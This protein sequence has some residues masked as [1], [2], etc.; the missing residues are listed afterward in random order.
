MGTSK[1]KSRYSFAYPQRRALSELE[2]MYESSR[3][4]RRFVGMD[5]SFAYKE[6][7]VIQS[8]DKRIEDIIEKYEKKLHISEKIRRCAEWA[9]LYG[10]ST[11]L[12]LARDGKFSQEEL[13]QGE[14]VKLHV[15]DRRWISHTGVIED[16]IMSENFS[17]PTSYYVTPA[18][19][20]AMV[21]DKSRIIKMN[22]DK[23]PLNSYIE[24]EYW[25]QSLLEPLYEVI[26]D[27]MAA[28]HASALLAQDFRQAIYKISNLEEAIAAGEEDTIKKRAETIDVVKSV[29]NAIV[30]GDNEEYDIKQNPVSG[31]ADIVDR[32]TIRL[33]IETGKPH[34]LLL[35]ESPSGLGA[36]GESE[37]RDY[38]DQVKAYQVDTLEP[39]HRRIYNYILANNGIKETNYEIKWNSL[40]SEEPK[41]KAEREKI[42]AETDKIYYDMEA[43]TSEEIRDNRFKEAGFEKDIILEG[44]YEFGQEPSKEDIETYEGMINGGKG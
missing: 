39:V 15:L 43:I 16:D 28:H 38:Y 20:E 7:F 25:G 37:K 41:V 40:W 34:T 4:A 29:I 44:D 10:G 24:N 9:N 19:G 23:L 27:Y 31:L 36:T 14:L 30:L 42:T 1:D 33:C 21:F 26:T 13:S 12:M 22:G 2:W 8:E 32:A 5:P 17:E 3:I 35:G 6:G 18:Y 11:I